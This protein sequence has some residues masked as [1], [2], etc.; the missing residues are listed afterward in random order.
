M[1]KHV[2][3]LAI[4]LL[5]I[6]LFLSSFH[7]LNAY[8]V[9]ETLDNLV[10]SSTMTAQNAQQRTVFDADGRHWVFFTNNSDLVYNSCINSSSSAW[11]SPTLVHSFEGALNESGD[12]NLYFDGSKL[13]L[14]YVDAKILYIRCGVFES[15]GLV[16]WDSSA[17]EIVNKSSFTYVSGVSISAS[18]I[19]GATYVWVSYYVYNLLNLYQIRYAVGIYAENVYTLSSDNEEFIGALNPPT[20]TFLTVNVSDTMFIY[21]HTN[22]IASR[23]FT[24]TTSTNYNQTLVN[25]LVRRDI[26]IL[27]SFG[28]FT[29]TYSNFDKAVVLVYEREVDALHNFISTGLVYLLSTEAWYTFPKDI[30]Y[31]TGTIPAPG[32]VPDLSLSIDE[33][34]GALFY[35]CGEATLVGPPYFYGVY[36]VFYI[37]N[38]SVQVK[39][40]TLVTSD[41]GFAG[42]IPI[43]SASLNSQQGFIGCVWADSTGS[44]LNYFSIT[45]VGTIPPLPTLSPILTPTPS[46]AQT[47][48]S[49]PT[50]PIPTAPPVQTPTAP[51]VQTQHMQLYFRMDTYAINGQR[52]YKMDSDYGNAYLTVTDTIGEAPPPYIPPLPTASP[53]PTPTPTPTPSPTSSPTPSPT[54]TPGP[55]LYN[56]NV[57]LGAYTG[58]LDGSVPSGGSVYLKMNLSISGLND[59]IATNNY[60]FLSAVEGDDGV[61]IRV[62]SDGV[63]LQ[64]GLGS[65]LHFVST[66]ISG[67]ESIVALYADNGTVYLWKN[68]AEIYSENVGAF[69]DESLTSYDV[70]IVGGA[71]SG[72][73]EGW[74]SLNN[75]APSPT[76]TPSPSITPSP[77]PTP[78]PSPSPTPILTNLLLYS[79]NARQHP[80]TGI[81][82]GTLNAG[83]TTTQTIYVYNPNGQTVT[84]S[85]YSYSYTPSNATNY[86]HLTWNRDSYQLSSHSTVSATLSMLLDS[87]APSTSFT[88]TMV[89]TGATP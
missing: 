68:G 84:L 58:S 17:Q 52:G 34:T 13:Y 50:S 65:Y 40:T 72:S 63:N 6:C 82:W 36:S 15:S 27:F 38:A 86:A 85:M 54:P 2:F 30:T 59:H 77:T 33:N 41:D 19:S 32:S 66:S 47:P 8:V 5:L 74:I 73:Y 43:F 88:Y 53:S 22:E 39:A 14:S 69:T 31:Q 56:A 49:T 11:V 7:L 81:T 44:K 28:S 55:F 62:F 79:D 75:I 29:A 57:T 37:S 23:Y 78:S 16:T 61:S 87:N 9:P 51:P 76:P 24:G 48:T 10:A 64:S 71:V 67:S 60:A 12:F 42:I 4:T 18:L 45:N 80:L 25:D 21:S 26:P 70:S 3:S 35:F 20:T 89:V 83:T 46:P 1:K